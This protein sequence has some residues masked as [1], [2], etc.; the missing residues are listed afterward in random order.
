[1]FGFQ[2]TKSQFLFCAEF[3]LKHSRGKLGPNLREIFRQEVQNE[4][5]MAPKREDDCSGTL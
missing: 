3:R 5:I 2:K 1:L 4:E